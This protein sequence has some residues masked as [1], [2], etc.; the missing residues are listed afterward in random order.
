MKRKEIGLDFFADF[1]E[2]ED[3]DLEYVGTVNYS[4]GEYITLAYQP[5]E[6][7]EDFETR[8]IYDRVEEILEKYDNFE[9]F[10]V[11]MKPGYYEG[12]NIEVNPG[13]YIGLEFDSD[14]QMIQAYKEI[15]QIR[16]L[17]IDLVSVERI[18]VCHPGWCTGWCDLCES[19][20]EINQCI[21]KM[22]FD[23]IS[24]PIDIGV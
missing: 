16:R 24:T 7:D 9:F 5:D 12:F 13:D 3:G 22:S 18:S 23:V 10:E 20:N 1:F 19:I 11:I 21:A 17:I 4:T 15:D 8:M 2:V 6:V 14:E